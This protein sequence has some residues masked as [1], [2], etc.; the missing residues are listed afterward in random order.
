MRE[1]SIASKNRLVIAASGSRRSALTLVE[2]VVVIAVLV[3]LMALLL[4]AVQAS[5]GAARLAHCRS[6]LRQ[7][8]L[9]LHAYHD[10]YDR[11]PPSPGGDRHSWLVR[12]LPFVE[13]RPLA[14]LIA[15]GTTSLDGISREPAPPLYLCP[16]DDA[17][18]RRLGCSYAGNMG[19]GLQA[20]GFDGMFGTAGEYDGHVPSRF[21]FGE[22]ADGLS[23]TAMCAEQMIANGT[24]DFRRSVFVTPVR[25]TRPEELAAFASY[26]WETALAPS[27]FS[28][29]N[30]RGELWTN[31]SIGW[32]LYNHVLGPNSCSCLNKSK[33][34]YSAFS[35]TSPHAGACPVLFGDGH[36]ALISGSIDLKAWRSMGSRCGGEPLTV[37]SGSPH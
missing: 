16:S 10:V 21:S 3:V 30:W 36:I 34:Q 5:R 35:A 18:H 4:P 24:R 12:I 20:H 9:G 29:D 14:E 17:P 25:L 28:D 11:L 33:V 1:R 23:Q 31:G 19:T 27:S 37:D 7:I 13:Q 8:G 32:T 22:C 2:V 15:K 6:N 26:C